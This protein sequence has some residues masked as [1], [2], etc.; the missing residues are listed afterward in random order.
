M[1]VALPQRTKHERP[2]TGFPQWFIVG[3]ILFWGVVVIGIVLFQVSIHT[4]V[5]HQCGTLSASNPYPSDP[6]VIRIAHALGDHGAIRA[7]W[8]GATN[9]SQ[10]DGPDT[11]VRIRG[12]GAPQLEALAYQS[13][14]ATNGWAEDSPVSNWE[15]IIHDDYNDKDTITGYYDPTCDGVVGVEMILTAKNAQGVSDIYIIRHE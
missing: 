15:R 2:P 1:K 14:P 5:R 13:E 8:G 4:D 10:F 3:A 12:S 11:A 9:A 7:C 6:T